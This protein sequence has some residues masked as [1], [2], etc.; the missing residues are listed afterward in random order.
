MI[1][2]GQCELLQVVGALRNAGRL[3]GRLH[4]GQEQ[5]DQDADDGDGD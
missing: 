3:A 1:V 5:S 4:C 2:R